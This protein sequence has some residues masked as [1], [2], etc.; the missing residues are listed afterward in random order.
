[1]KNEPQDIVVFGEKSGKNG[2]FLPRF[3]WLF[4]YL[5]LGKENKEQIFRPARSKNGWPLL[6][7]YQKIEEALCEGTEGGIKCLR[8]I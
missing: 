3:F 4:I 1:M 2:R 7:E 5:S 8:F 6:I